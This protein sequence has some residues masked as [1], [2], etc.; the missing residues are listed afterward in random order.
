MLEQSKMR[1]VGE[2]QSESERPMKRCSKLREG[3]SHRKRRP[4]K[5]G[6]EMHQLGEGQSESPSM[7]NKRLP[8]EGQSESH[9]KRCRKLGK[10]RS[11]SHR[12]KKK[13]LLKLGGDEQLDSESEATRAAS[14][15]ISVIGDDILLEILLRLPEART[16]IRC[17]SVCK[18]WFSLVSRLDDLY[19]IHKFNHHHTQKRLLLWGP[20]EDINS[21]D[22]QLPYTLFIRGHYISCWVY[23]VLKPSHI[24]PYKDLF[25]EKSMILYPSLSNCFASGSIL[26]FLNWPHAFIVSSCYDLLLLTELTH[27]SYIVCNPL[28]RQ[29]VEVPQAPRYMYTY[30]YDGDDFGQVISRCGFVCVPRCSCNKLS[31]YCNCSIEYKVVLITANE[32]DPQHHA[33]IF[34]SETGKWFEYSAFRSPVCLSHWHLSPV[35]CNGI[36]YWPFGKNDFEGIAAVDLFKESIDSEYEEHNL[37]RFHSI[38]LPVEF[39]SSLNRAFQENARL[40]VVRGRLRLAQFYLDE[41][42]GSYVLKA[43]ELEGATTWILVH[44]VSLK[45]GHEGLYVFLI[46]LHPEDGDAFFFARME[47]EEIDI[48][49]YKIGE[50]SFEEYVCDF[51]CSSEWVWKSLFLLTLK[52]TETPH[53]IP[54]ELLCLKLNA[55]PSHKRKCPLAPQSNEVDHLFLLDADGIYMHMIIYFKRFGK[56]LVWIVEAKSS[57]YMVTDVRLIQ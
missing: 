34:S 13:K 12:K 37:Q 26:D 53:G 57:F 24:E 25:S 54:A 16:V 39:D 1:K 22:S 17:S 32:C 33:V 19:F 18:R 40:A 11:E 21:D 51:P 49:Q 52:A 42:A 28:T 55:N 38:S 56:L 14:K 35:A 46:A 9:V 10:G 29:F 4:G 36:V 7:N 5:T 3:K 31:Y 23:P 6:K 20:N 27:D 2:A 30:D 45:R 44:H 8:G 43:W 48:C 41:E 50:D 15:F 47:Y